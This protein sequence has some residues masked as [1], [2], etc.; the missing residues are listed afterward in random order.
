[1][2]A[3]LERTPAPLRSLRRD[4]PVELARVVERMM[5]K[6]PA[7]RYQTPAEVAA[8]LERFVKPKTPSRKRW[9]GLAAALGFVA[10]LIAGVIIYVQ[11]DQGT[12]TVET[13][14]DKIAVMIEKAGG[15]KIIDKTNNREYLLRPGEYKLATGDYSIK[16]TEPL[17]DLEFSTKEFKL[18]RGGEIRVSATFVRKDLWFPGA[19]V[20][21]MAFTKDGASMVV[22]CADHM[23]R[24]YDVKT[25]ALRRTL[26]GHTA[27]V[28]AVVYSRDEKELVSCSGEFNKDQTRGEIIIWDLAT[29]TIRGRIKGPP[30]GVCWVI[31]S[32]DEKNL[33]SCGA[34]GI[35][36]MWDVTT[37]RQIKMAAGDNASV[38]RIL[39]TPDGNLLASAGMD[40]TVRFRRPDTLEEIRQITAHPNGVG[41]LAFSPN[42]KYLVTASRAGALPTPGEIK[43]W[44][45]VTYEEVRQIK[46][47]TSK[48]LSL[49]VSPDNKLLATGGGF[50]T[51]FGEVML[52]DLATGA[53]RGRFPYHKEWV[54]CVVF[55]PDGTLLASGGGYSHALRGEIHLWDVKRFPFPPGVEADTSYRGKPDRYPLPP[56][57]VQAPV[58]SQDGPP[59]GGL[60]GGKPASYWLDQ[61]QDANWKF[62]VE[63]VEALGSI[64]QKNKK[65][66]P[67]LVAALSDKSESVGSAAVRAVAKVGP[68]AVPALLEVI[69]EKKSPTLQA[70]AA[71]AIGH[72]G[73]PA[74]AAVPLLVQMLKSSDWGVRAFSDHRLGRHRARCEGG[75][76]GDCGGLWQLP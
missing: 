43:V 7:A 53:V 13:N 44:D 38:R 60:Y 24:V 39:F 22:A 52:F 61:L 6:D 2:K 27:T 26:K 41:T 68:D 72:I 62:R 48:V 69:K 4:V 20:F 75:A 49:T 34:D 12:I 30:G 51:G 33:Y 66:I 50:N 5:A 46:G 18:A 21:D 42:G 11:T 19:N 3:H 67:T 14:D 57:V 15:V 76:A 58:V 63:A 54:E 59:N 25:Q 31:Y 37:L 45:M 8:A 47:Q 70:R 32:P 56:T 1:M 17:A 29:G 40:G 73:P 35:I 28:Y 71:E 36:R 10:A 55:S 74:K 65:L 16:V 64:A 9:L 23:V